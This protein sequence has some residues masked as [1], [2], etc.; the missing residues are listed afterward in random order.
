[1]S[2]LNSLIVLTGP[3]GVGKG[4]LLRPLLARHP[5]LT[6]SISATTRSPRPGE[7]HGQHYYFLDRPQFEALIQ[8]NALLEWAEYAGNYYGTPRQAVN[9]QIQQGHR[10]ILEIELEGARQIR[11]AVPD[12]LQ[13]FVRPPS[14]ADLERRI[15]DRNQDSAAA[16]AQ[17]LAQ[18][19]VEIAA[20]HEFDVQITN[21][22]LE[23]ALQ[24]LE[25]AI[26]VAPH[27]H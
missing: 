10:V 7:V 22:N 26:N 27:C 5:E 14:M 17:R 18:A 3:S 16:I 9:D 24:N 6:L 12:A 19:Q 8:Q 23:V 11:Q 25:A 1:M 21:D 2:A 13:V 15:R 4:T 20:A